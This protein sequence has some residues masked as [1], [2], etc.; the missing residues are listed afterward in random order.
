M[1]TQD[2]DIRHGMAA[3]EPGVILHYVTAGDGDRTIVLLH[4]FPQTWREWR[5]VMPRLASA[6]YRVVAVDYRGAGYS[7]RP[8]DGYDKHT[9]ASD[10][11][12]LIKDELRIAGPIVLVGHDIGLMVAYAYSQMFRD[13]VSHLAVIDAPLPGTQVFDRLRADPRVWQFAFHSVR[14]IPE[15]L[16]AG[17]ERAYLQAFFNARLYNIAAITDQELDAYVSAYS[18]AGALRAGLELYR[19]FDRDIEDNRQ[20]LAAHGRLTIPV[21]A[22]GGQA[23]TTGPL[24]AEMMREVAEDVTELRVPNAAHWIAEENPQALVNG[25]IGFL[26]DGSR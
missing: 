8:L 15:M 10:I 1:D 18:A 12:R 19:A 22:V 7:S 3:L 13:H 2:I 11:R 20:W 17:R 9:M 24:M 23:S 25:L 14:D 21:L 26:E 5:H 6:G 4:G 16:I